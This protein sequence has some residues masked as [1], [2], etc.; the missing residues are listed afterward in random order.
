MKYLERFS[1]CLKLLWNADICQIAL[2]NKIDDCY[3]RCFEKLTQLFSSILNEFS[4][5]DNQV[6][7]ENELSEDNPGLNENKRRSIA[8]IFQTHLNHI[9]ALVQNH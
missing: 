3:M 5:Q 6:L 8:I 4:D 9:L 2:N 1:C 7:Q